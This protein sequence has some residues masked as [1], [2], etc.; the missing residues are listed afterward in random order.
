[1]EL[2]EIQEWWLDF[3]RWIDGV[4]RGKQKAVEQD[5]PIEFA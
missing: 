1:M 5:A 2:D 3:E 4:R